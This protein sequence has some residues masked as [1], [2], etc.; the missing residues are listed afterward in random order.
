[1]A[2]VAPGPLIQAASP[3]AR[4]AVYGA[5]NGDVEK[6]P[7]RSIFWKQLSICG[8]TMG[9]DEDFSEMLAFVAAHQLRPQ[10][11]SVYPWNKRLPPL[12]A[13]PRAAS[14]AKLSSRYPDA[15]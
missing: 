14:R 10:L 11:D 4:I 7:L 12:N 15:H 3:G 1:M 5:T 8:S 13:W 9:S 2:A 6:L